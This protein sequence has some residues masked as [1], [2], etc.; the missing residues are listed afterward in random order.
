LQIARKVAVSLLVCVLLFAGV[1]IFAFTDLFNAVEARFYDRATLNGLNGELAAYTDFVGGY[2]D[3]LRDRFFYILRNDAVKSSFSVNRT[4]EDIYERGRILD[5]LCVSMPELLWI[6]FI[7]T[8]GNNIYHSTDHSG[9]ISAD[10]GTARHWNY[11]DPPE[12]IPPGR[13]PAS[14]ANPQRV[15]FDEENGRLVFCF[16]FYD[17]MEIRRGEALFAVSIRA[18]G[19]RFI[20]TAHIRLTDDV[21]IVSNPDGIVVGI[22][23]HKTALIKSAIVSVWTSGVYGPGR[24]SMPQSDSLAMLSSKT[25]QGV[26][27]GLVVPENLFSLPATLK[28]LLAGSA[29]ITL[30]VVFFLMVNAKQDAVAVVQSRLKELQVSLMYEYYQLM[31]DMDWAVWRRELEQRRDDVKN[32]LCR[33]IK[34]KKGGDIEG[35]INSFFNRSWDGLIAAIGSRTGMI[36]T[37]DEAKLEAILSRVLSASKP[38][39]ADYDYE[40]QAPARDDYDLEEFPNADAPSGDEE[41]EAETAESDGRFAGGG[42]ADDWEE[43]EEVKEVDGGED[44]SGRFYGSISLSAY[45]PKNMYSSL[46]GGGTAAAEPSYGEFIRGAPGTAPHNIFATPKTEAAEDGEP[47]IKKNSNGIDY[48]NSAALTGPSSDA[49][50]I[51]PEMKRLVESVLRKPARL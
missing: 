38:S 41:H 9:Q 32:E 17:S 44:A 4:G 14:G 43:A 51:D 30:F 1:C 2:L 8:A 23:P 28:A 5:A 35:Y 48:I 12:Y 10:S 16:P 7:D 47:V 40:F 25:D 3:E 27:V 42:R 24:L 19:A 21:S 45:S 29:F 15:V 37:F 13:Q 36:T 31:G 50:G 39:G 49:N 6:R 46:R 34:I 18:L 22:P 20:R 11:H 26:F 33:G